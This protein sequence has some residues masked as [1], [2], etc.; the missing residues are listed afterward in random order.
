MSTSPAVL[1]GHRR[2]FTL[3]EILIVV[4]IL[5]ILAAI[6]LP[7]LSSASKQ[8][9]EGVMREELQFMRTAISLYGATHTGA[10]GIGAG[11]T[12]ES[13]FVAHLTG[14]TNAV[15]DTSATPS[16]QFCL[17][18]Y[19]SRIPSNP[20]LGKTGVRILDTGDVPAAMV[21]EGGAWGWIYKPSTMEFYANSTAYG[22]GGLNW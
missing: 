14:V 4:V 11:G 8:S 9:R 12:S 19:L 7:D 2:G 5:G 15:G 20:F 10:P 6:V 16:S 17:G 13:L 3:I 21:D 22:P 18:P 1:L